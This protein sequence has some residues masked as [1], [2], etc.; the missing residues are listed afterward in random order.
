MGLNQILEYYEH[1]YNNIY[2]RT[3]GKA[4]AVLDDNKTRIGFLEITPKNRKEFYGTGLVLEESI[5]KM[6]NFNSEEKYLGSIIGAQSLDFLTD[7]SIKYNKN[8]LTITRENIK[9]FLKKNPDSSD[10]ASYLNKFSEILCEDYATDTFNNKLRNTKATLILKY[11][12]TM[13]DARKEL[14]RQ[15]KE[16]I[17]I[18]IEQ[19][20]ELIQQ[21]KDK[22]NNTNDAE[23]VKQKNAFKELTGKNLNDYIYQSWEEFSKVILL[24]QKR[25]SR[26]AN[27][28]ATHNVAKYEITNHIDTISSNIMVR[29]RKTFHGIYKINC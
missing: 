17:P 25:A 29:E 16:Q 19:T 24:T 20:Y 18:I 4:I 12:P 3:D 9:E 1:T 8:E 11:S 13:H 26:R 21:L 10:I 15:I 7:P 28:S 5:L 14:R 2:L 23:L 27:F 6:L 22:I